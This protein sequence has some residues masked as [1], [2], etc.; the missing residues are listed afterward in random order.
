ML[1]APQ[2]GKDDVNGTDGYRMA[3]SFTLVELALAILII[4]ALAAAALPL[5]R[6][7]STEAKIAKVKA[8][9]EV[10]KGAS[11][12]YYVDTGLWPHDLSHLATDPGLLDWKGPYAAQTVLTDPWGR[13]YVWIIAMPQ[14]ESGAM[15][16]W[17]LSGGSQEGVEIWMVPMEEGIF[18]SFGGASNLTVNGNPANAPLEC[19]ADDIMGLLYHGRWSELEPRP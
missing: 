3:R 7:W 13:G 12:R 18:G 10:L 9:F 17:I 5:F 16:G 1:E 15:Y 14:T 4:A 11:R 2:Q 19:A 8:D 6:S